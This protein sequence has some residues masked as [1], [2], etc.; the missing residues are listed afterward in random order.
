MCI[1]VHGAVPAV[2]DLLKWRR[3]RQHKSTQCRWDAGF[4][5]AYRGMQPKLVAYGLWRDTRVPDTRAPSAT[6]THSMRPPPRPNGRR[7]PLTDKSQRSCRRSPPQATRSAAWLPQP[8]G[9]CVSFC[10]I[11]PAA[12]Q[13]HVR[14]TPHGS[15]ATKSPAKTGSPNPSIRGALG[16]APEHPSRP[17]I[18]AAVPR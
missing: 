6:L 12:A 13:T 9:R 1:R 8:L 5:T 17:R 7:V 3:N 15:F 14:E 2:T 10:C 16:C 11:G 18:F 4:S